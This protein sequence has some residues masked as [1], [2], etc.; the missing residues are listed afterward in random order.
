MGMWCVLGGP[1]VKKSRFQPQRKRSFGSM[2]KADGPELQRYRD[3]VK[4]RLEQLRAENPDSRKLLSARYAMTGGEQNALIELRELAEAGLLPEAES[5]QIMA[6][7]EG[8]QK[9]LDTIYQSIIEIAGKAWR[10]WRAPGSSSC[11]RKPC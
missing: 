7:T 2:L 8:L 5:I 9:E 4:T 1:S 6:E 11:G 3:E 10:C